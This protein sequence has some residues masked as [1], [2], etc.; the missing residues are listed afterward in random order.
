[1]H[2]LGSLGGP[3]TVENSQNQRGQIT[4]WSY[5]NIT[6]NKATGLPTTDPFLW[7]RGHMIDL[8]TLGGVFGVAN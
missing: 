7:Q 8:G 2:D 5:T 3:D 6:P 1:M 4:G